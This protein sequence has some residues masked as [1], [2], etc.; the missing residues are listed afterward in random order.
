VVCAKLAACASK[1]KHKQD[2]EVF[3]SVMACILKEVCEGQ[4][5]ARLNQPSFGPHPDPLPQGRGE[6]S[7]TRCGEFR[8][9][10]QSQNPRMS[11]DNAPQVIHA[12]DALLVAAKPAGLLAVPGRGVDK[13]HCLLAQLQEKFPDALVVHRLDMATS[14]L[15]LFARGLAAQRHLSAQF[16]QRQVHKRY[17]ALVAGEVADEAGTCDLPL[18][19]DWP[20]RPLQKVDVAH[21]KP[22]L[23]HW[24]VLHRQ[25]EL[26][27]LSLTPVTGRSHQLRV[28]CAASGFAIVGDTL[29]GGR[30]APRLMLHAAWLAFLHP[31]Q[32]HALAFEHAAPF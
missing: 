17:E 25:G 1:L 11:S 14:G 28:H 20:N 13:Q 23:T 24:Q 22:S 15:M 7:R 8:K 5:K 26:T 9:D 19:A 27:R 31:L 12:D 4:V 30:A 6:N 32:G 18:L 3:F 29:Y 10:R 21:G 16:A 2:Q